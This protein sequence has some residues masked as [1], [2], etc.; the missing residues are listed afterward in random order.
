MS[1]IVPKKARS[2]NTPARRGEPVERVEAVE[3]DRDHQ[4]DPKD[5]VEHHRRA[6]ALGRQP[7]GVGLL[8]HAE[9]VEDPIRQGARGR[10]TAGHD[11]S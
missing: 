2:K 7:E 11:V 10:G 3:G 8:G 1:R 6:R 4:R 5:D 9:F